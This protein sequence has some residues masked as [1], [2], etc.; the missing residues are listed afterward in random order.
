LL[1]RY[2]LEIIVKIAHGHTIVSEDDPYLTQAYTAHEAID[3]AGPVG[4]TPIDMFP[5][6]M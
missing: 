3:S 5:I 4:S 1:D 6:R 2:A